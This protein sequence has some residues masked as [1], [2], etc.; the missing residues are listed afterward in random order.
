LVK[1][2]GL[3]LPV[4]VISGLAFLARLEK[5]EEILVSVGNTTMADEDTLSET[6]A[7]G[8]TNLAQAT[9]HCAKFAMPFTEGDDYP[10]KFSERG[11][12]VFLSMMSHSISRILRKQKGCKEI[13]QIWAEL[14]KALSDVADGKSA[15]LFKP[16]KEDGT[17]PP[18]ASVHREVYFSIAAA[19]Y[20]LAEA[21]EKKNVEKE[22][23]RKLKVKTSQL[24]NFRN[25]LTR[26]NPNIK[27]V[28]ALRYYDGVFL[29]QL[30]VDKNGNIWPGAGKP[31][32]VINWLKWFDQISF[33]EV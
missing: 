20:D 27:S 23:A 9:R 16:L 15:N 7:T 2:A 12:L 32:S 11:K 30:Q 1:V 33:I 17:Q 24:K 28:E 31:S 25:N 6:V 3:T 26:A 19:V 4:C 10:D 21:G 18:G 5:S 13:S 29:G 8:V 22:I 14:T